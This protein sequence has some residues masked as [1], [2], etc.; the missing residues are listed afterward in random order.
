[1][2]CP[3]GANVT[4]NTVPNREKAFFAFVNLL[5]VDTAAGVL[6]G[7]W[8][9]PHASK[10][11]AFESARQKLANDH[12]PGSG[13]ATHENPPHPRWASVATPLERS[14]FGMSFRSKEEIL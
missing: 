5:L 1:V 7:G 4:A 10:G 2:L 12:D 8:F 9:N 3:F 14:V 6:M 13:C 11:F